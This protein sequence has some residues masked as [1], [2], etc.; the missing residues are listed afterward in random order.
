MKTDVLGVYDRPPTDTNAILLKEIGEHLS[1][2]DL[3]MDRSFPCL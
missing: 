1:I 2:E 3:D